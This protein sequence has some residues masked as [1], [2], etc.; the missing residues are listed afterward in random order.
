MTTYTIL[1]DCSQATLVREDF[2]EKL[3]IKGTKVDVSIETITQ[4]G[5]DLTDM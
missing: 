1:D 2:A 4:D 5:E 3:G